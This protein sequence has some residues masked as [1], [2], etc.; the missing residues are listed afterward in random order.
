MLRF[1]YIEVVVVEESIRYINVEEK[2]VFS[3]RPEQF[4]TNFNTVMLLNMI[5]ML[6]RNDFRDQ[7]AKH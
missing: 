5:I 6:T 4:M 1:K 7:I 3:P 2:Q